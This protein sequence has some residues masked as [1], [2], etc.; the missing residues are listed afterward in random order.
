[1]GLGVSSRARSGV[2][3][4]G[5]DYGAHGDFKRSRESGGLGAWSGTHHVEEIK[6]RA[7]GTRGDSGPWPV[8]G[9][10]AHCC[11]AR[12]GNMGGGRRRQVGPISLSS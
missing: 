4:K 3:G 12:G 2:R 1:M 11:A 10:D 9:A 7:P 8:D 6:G 5:I